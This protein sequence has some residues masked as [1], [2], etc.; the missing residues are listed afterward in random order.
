MVF[1]RQE[2][3]Y[4]T[5]RAE[6]SFFPARISTVVSMGGL[7]LPGR[8]LI[9]YHFLQHKGGYWLRVERGDPGHKWLVLNPTSGLGD[10]SSGSYEGNHSWMVNLIGSIYL[11]FVLVRTILLPSCP[12]KELFPVILLNQ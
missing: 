6:L 3:L 5:Q 12:F 11:A 4:T 7:I 10:F 8:I 1:K 2:E 9:S